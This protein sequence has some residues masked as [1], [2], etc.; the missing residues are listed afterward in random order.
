MSIHS[1][2][3]FYFGREAA[4]NANT[5]HVSVYQIKDNETK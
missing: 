1:N 2:L 5:L 3:G 4:Q